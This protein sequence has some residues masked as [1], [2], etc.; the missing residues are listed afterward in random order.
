MMRLL[1]INKMLCGFISAV[2]ILSAGMG[3]CQRHNITPDFA[4]V[5]YAG[6]IG[7]LSIGAG[8]NIFK[9]KGRVSGHFGMVPE[10]RGGHLDIIA[11]KLFYTPKVV[12]VF[13][14]VV[15][16]P[17]DVGLMVSYHFGDNF[18]LNVPNYFSDDNY[19]WWHTAM[20]IHLAIESSASLDLGSEGIFRA[21]T[22]Y[23]EFNT[24]DLYVVSFVNNPR[25]LALHELVKLGAGLRFIFNTR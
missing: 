5:Q 20:R 23:L 21:L 18:K 16:N 10:N 19:Y 6:S 25:S 11:V 14:R 13:E 8:Y 24:N 12:Q 4:S 1:P 2:L 9:D 17:A 7:Y 3:M 15:I 22:A